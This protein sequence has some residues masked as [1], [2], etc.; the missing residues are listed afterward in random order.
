MLIDSGS[1]LTVLSGDGFAIS[2]RCFEIRNA[3]GLEVVPPTAGALARS[4]AR[5]RFLDPPVVTVPSQPVD[6]WGWEVGDDITTSFVGGVLGGNVLRDFAIALRQSRTR[7]LSS[8]TFERNF[9]G[10]ENALADQGRAYLPVQYPGR[11]LGRTADDRCDIGGIDCL[12]T[13]QFLESVEVDLPFRASRM[14]MDACLAPP[15]CDAAISEETGRCVNS[16]GGDRSTEECTPADATIGGGQNASLVVATAVPGL[17]LFSDSAERM[18][19]EI[20]GLPSCATLNATDVNTLACLE[21]A[22]G[23]LALPGWAALEGLSVIKVRAL[24]IVPG[25]PQVSNLTPCERHERR[26][27]GLAAQCEGFRRHLRPWR[28]SVPDGA[29]IYSGMLTVGE[30]GW[31]EGQ[32]RPDPGARWIRTLIVPSF[33]PLA[34]AVRRDTGPNAIDPDGM[35]GSAILADVEL[36]LDYTEEDVAPGLRATCISPESGQCRSLVECRGDANAEGSDSC[37]HGL[38]SDVLVSVLSR[39][40]SGG[41]RVDDRCCA[42]LSVDQVSKLQEVDRC[43]GYDGL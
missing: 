17:V 36:V 38:P 1:P 3:G 4:V 15:P 9:P 30:V 39:P 5:L 34:V 35:V 26:V 24:S 42:A 7:A 10:S 20:A 33:S 27:L 12:I 22:V 19:G 25:T 23:R 14:V 43:D 8:V 18:F 29:S 2:R 41:A 28:P 13:N 40:V 37:C 16:P 31:A 11:L 21:P 32:D 6:G